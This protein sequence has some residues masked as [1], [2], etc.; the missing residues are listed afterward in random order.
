MVPGRTKPPRAQPGPLALLAVVCAVGIHICIS[1]Q[2]SRLCLADGDRNHEGA[3][4]RILSSLRGVEEKLDALLSAGPI[5]DG[6]QAAQGL[7]VLRGQ[8]D[9]LLGELQGSILD[10]GG[11]AI[12]ED[13]G[14]GVLEGGDERLDGFHRDLELGGIGMGPVFKGGLEV[15]GREGELEAGERS[16]GRIRMFV[17]VF[18]GINGASAD[19]DADCAKR[20]AAIRDT[21]FPSS[22]RVDRSRL[23][24]DTGVVVRFVIGHS[25]DWALD[26]EIEREEAEH[27]D[28]LRLQTIESH[29][30]LANKAEGF[31]TAV[32]SLYIADWIAKVDDDMYLK[33]DRLLL[34]SK[35]WDR[36]GAGYIG[37]M[38]NGVISDHLS[39]PWLEHQHLL[40]HREYF[41]HAQS[42]LYVLSGE[43]ADSVIRL[44]TG[45]L[46]HFASAEASVGV[47]MLGHNVTYFE[48]M[49]LCSDGCLQQAIGVMQAGCM[50]LC[51]PIRD[52]HLIHRARHCQTEAQDPLPY[53]ESEWG[54]GG[55]ESMK[56]R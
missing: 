55:F 45:D 50:G 32:A 41:L 34:A 47:W 28:I 22:T 53:L 27:G 9:W 36:M 7:A 8:L 19:Q 33:V 26:G 29:A 3:S 25:G 39:S 4:D 23:E 24:Q 52:M 42:K 30:G 11:R 44:N 56:V 13:A 37:C 5:G 54:H 49:R 15:P 16:G 51:D 10:R 12:D 17:G 40:I 20:R 21:W 6:A 43:T 31:F 18:S 46:R 35:Q 14:T 1:H 38:Q 48:D 2:R